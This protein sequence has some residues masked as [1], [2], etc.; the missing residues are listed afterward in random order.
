MPNGN[1]Y[2]TILH[3]EEPRGACFPLKLLTLKIKRRTARGGVSLRKSDVFTCFFIFPGRYL[4]TCS[5]RALTM[6]K[7]SQ[8]LTSVGQTPLSLAAPRC[9]SRNFT[10]RVDFY[11]LR[12]FAPL[13]PSRATLLGLCPKPPGPTGLNVKGLRPLRLGALRAYSLILYWPCGPRG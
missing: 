9:S 12:G 11:C 7:I 10:F 8:N 1:P 2:A 13:L 4:G 3:H 5:E 6:G